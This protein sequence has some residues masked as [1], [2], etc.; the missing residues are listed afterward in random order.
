VDRRHKELSQQMLLPNEYNPQIDKSSKI[1]PRKKTIISID[2]PTKA[3]M[4]L[5]D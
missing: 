5:D 2:D 3:N 4:A 1:S